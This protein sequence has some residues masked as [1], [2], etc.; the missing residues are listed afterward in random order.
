MYYGIYGHEVVELIESNLY[1]EMIF[2]CGRFRVGVITGVVESKNK[3]HL[4]SFT[5][6]SFLVVAYSTRKAKT[7]PLYRSDRLNGTM[8]IDS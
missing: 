4:W 7:S 8:P 3:L 5:G 6:Y 1:T 2:S